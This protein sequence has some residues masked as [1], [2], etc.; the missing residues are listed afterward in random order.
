MKIVGIITLVVSMVSLGLIVWL[1]VSEPWES[2]PW[3]SEPSTI[4]LPTPQPTLTRCEALAQQISSA[5][6]DMAARIFG[7]NWIQNG[8]E[9]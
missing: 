2:E 1:I 3:E 8:C 9:K 4:S 5:Q 6:T 7:V